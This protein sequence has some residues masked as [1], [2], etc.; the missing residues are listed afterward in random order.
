M[1]DHRKLKV[2]DRSRQ[3]A[4]EVHG[5]LE[6]ASRRRPDLIDQL[7]RAVAS[8]VLNI[9]EGAGEYRPRE[10]ARFYRMARRSANEASGVLDLLVD[11]EILEETHTAGVQRDIAETIAMLVRLAQNFDRKQ[12]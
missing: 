10:K 5:L 12:A 8:V 4:R 6:R 3:I 2:Y 1:L 11:I 7:N 9:A